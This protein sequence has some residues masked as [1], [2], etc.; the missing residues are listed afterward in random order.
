MYPHIQMELG[1]FVVFFVFSGTVHE[2]SR[3]DAFANVCILVVFV[4]AQLLIVYVYLDSL[5]KSGELLLYITSPTQR[6][7]L[8]KVLCTPLIALVVLF[9]LI[10]DVE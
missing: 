8:D 3:N 5:H 2:K 7:N 10:V 1:C 6:T 4:Y 9:P